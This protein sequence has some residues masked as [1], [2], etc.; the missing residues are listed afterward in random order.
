MATTSPR[1]CCRRR[2]DPKGLGAPPWAAS[3]LH[4]S[5]CRP[6][7]PH[8]QSLEHSQPSQIPRARNITPI[9]TYCFS[10]YTASSSPTPSGRTSA[11]PSAA[12]PHSDTRGKA[13]CPCCW[14]AATS[15][16][17]PLKGAPPTHRRKPVAGTLP[18]SPSPVCLGHACRHS[19]CPTEKHRC[20]WTNTSL[21]MYAMGISAKMNTKAHMQAVVHTQVCIYM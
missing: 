5:S 13:Y 10:A 14:P 12:L 8:G 2:E 4:A 18:P 19:A 6:S 15:T 3:M 7:L 21:Y 9:M 20:H 1:H 11:T 16:S 17:T